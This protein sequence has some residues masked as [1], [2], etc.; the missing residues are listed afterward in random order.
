MKFFF[1]KFVENCQL[2]IAIGLIAIFNKLLTRKRKKPNKRNGTFFGDH[3]WHQK[4]TNFTFSFIFMIVQVKTKRLRFEKL[5]YDNF[6]TKRNDFTKGP[7]I[8]KICKTSCQ[9]KNWSFVELLPTIFL[10]NNN[11]LVIFEKKL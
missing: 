10:L 1:C 7:F 6:Q 9:Q 2:L 8:R 4:L 5:L 3:F 11:F